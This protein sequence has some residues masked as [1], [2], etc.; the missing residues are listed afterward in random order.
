[1]GA[2][3]VFIV[4]AIAVAF[5]IGFDLGHACGCAKERDRG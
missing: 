1:M 5:G 2:Y 4:L 3:L